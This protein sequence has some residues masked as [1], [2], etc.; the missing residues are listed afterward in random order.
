MT[1]WQSYFTGF[2]GTKVLHSE[3]RLRFCNECS[4]KMH[5]L[6]CKRKYLFQEGGKTKLEHWQKN[7]VHFNLV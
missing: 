6:G 2:S 3:L 7:Y 5:I 1:E 4:I